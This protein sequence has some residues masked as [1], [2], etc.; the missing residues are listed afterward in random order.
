[1]RT[2]DFSRSYL[3]FRIDHKERQS[4]TATH[5]P[6]FTLNNARIL[7]DCRCEIS[8]RPN[9]ESQVFVQGASCK[10][11]RVGVERDIWTQPNADFVPIFSRDRFLTIKTFD[12]ADRFATFY[13]PSRGVQPDRQSGTIVD[14]G[15]N[16]VRIDVAECEGE[17]LGTPEA[18]VNAV[19]AN[20]PLVGRTVLENER[21]RAVL[22]Y[23]VKTINANE[24]DWIYQT[25]TGPILFPDLER[26]PAALIEGLEL[27]FSAFNAPGWTEF[28]VRTPTPVGDGIQV[29]HYSRSVHLSAANTLIRITGR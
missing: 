11:E 20:E 21:Y 14:A 2:V 29:Y 22:D 8:E 16:R 18:I 10:T 5:R 25:D 7:L 23:P 24:R 6:A 19:L 15:F 17:A 27:A 1:M 12:R 3:T 4:Q 13:P 9:G 26:E 28:L